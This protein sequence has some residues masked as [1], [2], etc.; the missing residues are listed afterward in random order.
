[1]LAT[2]SAISS[3]CTRGMIARYRQI[4]HF[5][6][7]VVQEYFREFDET[8]TTHACFYCIV[9]CCNE[10]RKTFVESSQRFAAILREKAAKK[11]YQKKTHP[12]VLQI[13]ICRRS[14]AP[15]WGGLRPF[16]TSPLVFFS[17]L[18]FE[19]LAADSDVQALCWKMMYTRTPAID[20]RGLG[21]TRS[22]GVE[23][24]VKIKW[25]RGD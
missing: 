20:L 21:S 4:C 7:N 9:M 6:Q 19:M 24:S 13:V 8:D 25:P 10:F 1:M 2:S 11:P 22:K 17:E 16:R 3:K 12:Y 23:S 14:C 5:F 15:T 18:S